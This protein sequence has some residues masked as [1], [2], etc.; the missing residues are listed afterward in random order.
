MYTIVY[1]QS[2]II[3]A[4]KFMMWIKWTL[5]CKRMYNNGQMNSYTF[6]VFY[7]TFQFFYFLFRNTRLLIK[8]IF[9]RFTK[10]FPLFS[11][12]FF[13]SFNIN[14]ILYFTVFDNH[15]SYSFNLF[16]NFCFVLFWPFN[17]RS[18]LNEKK[19]IHET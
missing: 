3:I 4:L 7:L 18:K 17:T 2:H 19:I 11:L 13:H 16:F 1:V 5:I 14:P 6:Y 8:E 15:F 9:N 12:F 10:F